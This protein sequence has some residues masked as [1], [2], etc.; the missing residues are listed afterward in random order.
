MKIYPSISVDYIRKMNTKSV[1]L[2]LG[3]KKPL[4]PTITNPIIA[5]PHPIKCLF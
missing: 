2:E 4:P 3:W 5:H 1:E